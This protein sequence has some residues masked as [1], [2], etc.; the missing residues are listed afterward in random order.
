MGGREGECVGREGGCMHGG[1]R[2]MEDLVPAQTVSTCP[3][4][5]LLLKAHLAL[6]ALHLRALLPVRER[7]TACGRS[8]AGH[9]YL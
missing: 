6:P 2:T 3:Y 4:L 5:H 7:V 9:M 1:G 8:R